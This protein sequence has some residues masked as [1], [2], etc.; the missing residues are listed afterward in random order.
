[1][2]GFDYAYLYPGLRKVTQAAGR[3]IRTREDRGVVYLI[4]DRFRRP[5]VQALLPA[6]W[7]LSPA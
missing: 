5:E 6:W 2:A 1:G 3:V 4:D 7:D